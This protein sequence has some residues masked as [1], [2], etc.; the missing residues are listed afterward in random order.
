MKAKGITDA[1]LIGHSMGGGLALS[2]AIAHPEAVNSLTLLSALGYPL[3]LPLY[4]S[5]ST[6]ISQLWVLFWPDNG[7]SL[8][9]GNRF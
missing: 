8:P 9:Q 3:D 7:S 4:L 1:H 2:L 6:H 5:L